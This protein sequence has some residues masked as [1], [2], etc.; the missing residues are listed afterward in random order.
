MKIKRMLAFIIDW[1]ICG[2]PAI[3]YSLLFSNYMKTTGKMPALLIV[4]FVL[5]T[6]A[7][8]I[9]FVLRDVIFNGRSLAKRMFKLCVIDNATGELPKKSILTI[10][11][12]FFFC[13]PIDAIVLIA[14]GKSIGDIAT[15]TSVVKK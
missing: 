15:Q 5:L 2:I 3:I 12:L 13:D 1:N 9:S 8:P 7:Y 4:I 10:R 11:N 6:L 14:C